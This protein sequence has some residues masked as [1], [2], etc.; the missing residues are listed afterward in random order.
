[1][2]LRIYFRT[3]SSF[4]ISLAIRPIVNVF[5][6]QHLLEIFPVT[7][8]PYFEVEIH[9]YS[10]LN[11]Y[12]CINSCSQFGVFFMACVYVQQQTLGTVRHS[13]LS[14]YIQTYLIE[15]YVEIKYKSVNI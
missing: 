5:L 1:M 11:I 4:F 10:T 2:M 15:E 12:D 9:R 3:H 7:E 8:I 13:A 14:K 6:I